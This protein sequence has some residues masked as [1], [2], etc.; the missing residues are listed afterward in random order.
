MED[1]LFGDTDHEQIVIE[2]KFIASVHEEKKPFKCDFR[3]I[4]FAQNINSNRT[5]HQ[6]MKRRRHLN[7]FFVMH[8]L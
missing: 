1:I 5:V 3:Y 4:R 7:A 2:T 6:F 8:V